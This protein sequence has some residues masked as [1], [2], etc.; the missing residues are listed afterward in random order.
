MIKEHSRNL[1]RH[2]FKHVMTEYRCKDEA[3]ILNLLFGSYDDEGRSDLV[4]K[5]RYPDRVKTKLIHRLNTLWVYP[6][7]VLLIPFRY[8]AFGNHQVNEN[9]RFG[10]L[11][12][13]LLGGIK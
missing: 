10:K 13:F 9:T 11:L 3:D 8:L 5:Y 2:E 7:F 12:S 6:I 4:V 1:H